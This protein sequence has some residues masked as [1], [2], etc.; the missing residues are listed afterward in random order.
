MA[1]MYI[2]H[3]TSYTIGRK[4]CRRRWGA[5]RCTS[6]HRENTPPRSILGRRIQGRNKTPKEFY[7]VPDI[8]PFQNQ[9]DATLTNIN[10]PWPFHQWGIEISRVPYAFTVGSIMYA[11]TSSCP[12]IAFPLS[13]ASRYQGNPGRAHWITAKNIL[14]YRRRTKDWVPVL[15][16]SDN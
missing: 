6:A 16:G 5:R 8:H 4:P 9:P 1:Q 10:S 11:M 12:D 7:E 2:L 3:G 13:M 14:K 15:G